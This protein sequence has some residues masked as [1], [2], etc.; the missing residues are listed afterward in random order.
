MSAKGQKVI[1]KQSLSDMPTVSQAQPE[2]EEPT[3]VLLAMLYTAAKALEGRSLATVLSGK[4]PTTHQ[5]VI[6]I[7]LPMVEMDAA[8]GFR[9]LDSV[10]K[11][12]TEPK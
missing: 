9:L 12:K 4:N 11:E 1:E 6:Y 8:L 2:V 10:G 5:P 7:R 3:E